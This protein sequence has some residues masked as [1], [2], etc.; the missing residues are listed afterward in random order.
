MPFAFIHLFF[1]WCL[2][3]AFEAITKRKIH[4]AGWF[5]LLFATLLPDADFLLDWLFGT[6][7]HRNF[8]HSLFFLLFITIGTYILL[9][10][11]KERYREGFSLAIATGIFSHLL[12]DFFSGQGIPLLWPSEMYFS[13]FGITAYNPALQFLKE[14]YEGLLSTTKFMLFDMAAGAA[15]LFYFILRKRIRF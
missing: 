11:L 4:P 7:L 9:T 13:I 6:S 3:K 10:L 5:L 15:W 2:G 14:N 1:A 8:T 12:L